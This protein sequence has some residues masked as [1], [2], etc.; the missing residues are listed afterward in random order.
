MSAVCVGA[1]LLLGALSPISNLG[2]DIVLLGNCVAASCADRRG[3][4]ETCAT[5]HQLSRREGTCCASPLNGSQTVVTS[6]KCARD[7]LATL[8]CTLELTPNNYLSVP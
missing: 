1:I 2:A 6:S 5:S 3:K 8:N 4:L 7:F